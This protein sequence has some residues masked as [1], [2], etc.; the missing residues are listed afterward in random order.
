MPIID[1]YPDWDIETTFDLD[2]IYG[3]LRDNSYNT[4]VFVSDL[5]RVRIN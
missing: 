1:L 5:D 2:V 3:T 4:S